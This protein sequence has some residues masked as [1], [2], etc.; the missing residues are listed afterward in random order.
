MRNNQTPGDD[1]GRGQVISTSTDDCPCWSY[2]RPAMCTAGCSID[3][4]WGSVAR[5]TGVSRYT[6]YVL[7]KKQ[8]H[9]YVYFESAAYNRCVNENDISLVIH[10][11]VCV[12]KPKPIQN[13]HNY[14]QSF[15]QITVYTVMA[16]PT[17][18]SSSLRSPINI[19]PVVRPSVCFMVLC[20]SLTRERKDQERTKRLWSFSLS[21]HINRGSHSNTW[22]DIKILCVL[23]SEIFNEKLRLG[24]LWIDG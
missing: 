3:R 21:L 22:S 10:V 1:G 19:A 2:S 8:P 7:S 20:L 18:W 16:L 15:I 5:S 17:M 6:C 12:F 11:V 9:I 14:Q 4:S 24:H 23:A 13:S